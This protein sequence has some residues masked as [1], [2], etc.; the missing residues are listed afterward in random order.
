MEKEI[1]TKEGVQVL[2]AE[3]AAVL[4]QMYISYAVPPIS[5]SLGSTKPF[6]ELYMCSSCVRPVG[7]NVAS[8]SPLE[9][10][11]TEFS[12][13]VCTFLF[14]DTYF[15]SCK[16]LHFRVVGYCVCICQA[17]NPATTSCYMCLRVCMCVMVC[18]CVR[19][20]FH[21]SDPPSWRYRSLSYSITEC[22]GVLP[23]TTTWKH[24]TTR[25]KSFPLLEI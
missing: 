19:L 10:F 3:M 20:N 13:S 7:G 24:A 25:V 11:I 4:Y 9:Y 6:R 5:L 17:A 21:L 22:P 14:K 15:D 18:V 8:A 1:I 2:S 12:V 23:Y 16:Q